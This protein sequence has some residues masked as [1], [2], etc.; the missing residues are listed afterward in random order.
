MTER[1]PLPDHL[2]LWEDDFGTKIYVHPQNEGC[3]A[4]QTGYGCCIHA[5]SDHKM[6]TWPRLWRTDGGFMERICPHGVGHPD[7]DDLAFRRRRFSKHVA[8]MY[9]IHGCDGCCAPIMEK[10]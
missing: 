5:P 10:L 6:K 3:G 8:E 2:D 9:A 4:P 7:P 1:W